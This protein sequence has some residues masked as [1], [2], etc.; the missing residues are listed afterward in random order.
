MSRSGFSALVSFD[1]KT[2]KGHCQSFGLP[3]PIVARGKSNLNS[4]QLSLGNICENRPYLIGVDEVGRGCLA[5]PVVSAAVA[6]P[7][8][9][10][11]K[12]LTA[13][14]AELDDSKKLDAATRERLSSL[15]R[16]CA[17]FAIASCSAAEIDEMNIL[18]ASLRSMDLAV[19]ALMKDLALA[20]DGALILVDGNK[21]I[22]NGSYKQ[23]TVI[24]G[25]SHS[26]S[27][28][29]A[30]V[31]AKVHRDAHMKELDKCYP[32]Y[33]FAGHKGY[34]AISHRKAIA[35]V[36]PCP[37]HRTSFRLLPEEKTQG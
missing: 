17:R 36:G 28:A 25:D 4:E 27:I 3:A 29:A 31:I 23:L 11:D 10:L 34:P 21:P 19:T 9:V 15:L 8:A 30:S 26:A 12:E 14:L 2:Y 20:S 37:E 32:A 5:G 6:L 7:F 22:K 16:S 35:E 24:K 33:G 13:A 18:N 1:L